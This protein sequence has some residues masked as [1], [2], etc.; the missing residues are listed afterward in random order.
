MVLMIIAGVAGLAVPI[1]M[2]QRGTALKIPETWNYATG[3]RGEP[4]T[5]TMQ[6]NG[7]VPPISWS[8]SRGELPSGLT[9]EVGQA[10]SKARRPGKDPL[11]LWR[12]HR[13]AQA[14]RPNERSR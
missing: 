6:A 11:C 7:G 8:I 13:I 1:W 14:G 12:R 10:A 2:V 3:V 9:L 5:G 4:Y